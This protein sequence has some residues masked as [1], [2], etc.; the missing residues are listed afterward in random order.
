M[1]ALLQNMGVYHG[2][3]NTLMS[4]QGLDGTYVCPP[5]QK[6]GRK[7]MAKGMS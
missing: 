6:M 7:A 4:E 3:G 2:G 5:F 1:P